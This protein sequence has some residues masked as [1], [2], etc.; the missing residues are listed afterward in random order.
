MTVLVEKV[1]TEIVGLS[2]TLK[3]FHCHNDVLLNGTDDTLERCRF[4][5]DDHLYA[6]ECLVATAKRTGGSWLYRWSLNVRTDDNLR[7]V[8]CRQQWRPFC[9]QW[10]VLNGE[11]ISYTSTLLKTLKSDFLNLPE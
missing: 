9:K 10:D 7:T 5:T 11:R 6:A 3:L 1:H 8:G 2:L 4:T